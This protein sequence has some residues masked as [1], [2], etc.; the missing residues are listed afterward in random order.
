MA[1]SVD[2]REFRTV[3]GS[4]P[5]GVVIV[6]ASTEAGPQGMTIGAFTSV[7]LEPP[8]V[9]F[10]PAKSSQTWPRI[11]DAG[12]FSVNILGK[13]QQELCRAFARPSS[14]KYDGVAWGESAHG[15]PHL[16]GALAWLDCDLDAVFEAGDHDI[17]LGR[18]IALHRG[19]DDDPLVFFR[20]KFHTI[21]GE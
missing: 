1:D 2:Q 16:D 11:R 18:V 10:L 13:E 4:F 21:D 20:G 9:A 8:L 3:L 7:S 14:E 12:K 17:A 6:T 5:T 15:T 19:S